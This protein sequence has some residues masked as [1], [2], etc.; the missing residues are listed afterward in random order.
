M[1]TSKLT[2]EEIYAA[3]KASDDRHRS[4]R[5]GFDKMYERDAMWH[6]LSNDVVMLWHV[7]KDRKPPDTIIEN[8]PDDSFA[9]VIDGKTH[10]FKLDEF[11]KWLRWA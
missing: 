3:E 8:V 4:R 7:P 9:L 5:Q 6:R 11:R 10:Y 1:R 2:A